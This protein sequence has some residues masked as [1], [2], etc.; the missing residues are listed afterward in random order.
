MWDPPA[1]RRRVVHALIFTAVVSRHMFVCLS[2]QQALATV[3]E[4]CERAWEFFGGV[5]A[6]LIPDNMSPIVADADPVNPTFTAGWLDYAQA[7][8]C[9][10]VVVLGKNHVSVRR[11]PPIDVEE[12]GLVN[13]AECHPGR[14]LR[15]CIGRRLAGPPG[16][17][18]CCRRRARPRPHSRSMTGPTRTGRRRSSPSSP[19]TGCRRRPP[20]SVGRP[21]RIPTWPGGSSPRDT[22]SATTPRPTR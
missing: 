19:A 12:H 3:I 11:L 9:G 21:P 8:G 17:T 15:Q 6:V 5:F 10:T 13:G 2:F 1:G 14:Y 20:S 7:R 18:T 4:G 22:R 16:F